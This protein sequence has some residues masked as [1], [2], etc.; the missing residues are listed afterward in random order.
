[1]GKS[2]V[3]HRSYFVSQSLDD[4]RGIRGVTERADPTALTWRGY[5]SVQKV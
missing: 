5:R 3:V 1:M 4:A 2:L